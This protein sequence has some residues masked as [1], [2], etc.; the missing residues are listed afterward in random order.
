[1]ESSFHGLKVATSSTA[2]YVGGFFQED[3]VI[4]LFV[5]LTED[6]GSKQE[7]ID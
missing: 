2:Y 7:A 1:M 6:F 4:T 5:R 3:E